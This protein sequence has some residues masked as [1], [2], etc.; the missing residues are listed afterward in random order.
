VA[1]GLGGWF[2]D[3]RED[4]SRPYLI[5]TATTI[6]AHG[7]ILFFRSDTGIALNNTGLI[8]NGL[9]CVLLKPSDK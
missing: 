1:I 7:Y 4:G 2:L 3:D 9:H 5:P 8:A 6:P